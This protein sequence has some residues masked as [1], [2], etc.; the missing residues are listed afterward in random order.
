[1]IQST[2]KIILTG[3]RACGKSVVGRLLALRLGIDF[4][5]MDREIEA[6]EGCSISAM[7]ARHGWP[8]FREREQQLLAELIGRERLVVAT[9][10]GAIMHEE[11]WQRLQATALVVWLR[12][13]IATIAARLAGDAATAGQRPSL[14]GETVIREI[15]G[16]LAERTPLYQKGS[17]L[18]VDT[19]CRSP[20]EIVALVAAALQERAENR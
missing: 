13:D 10:G 3:Y 6:R 8:Y 12:A 15:E 17:H 20:E 16:V 5:D 7:V 14:T 11:V 18:A 2:L 9:G 1:M 19:G 4:L